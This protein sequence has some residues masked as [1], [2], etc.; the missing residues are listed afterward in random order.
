MTHATI[1]FKLGE[2]N[3]AM[4]RPGLLQRADELV[5]HTVARVLLAMAATVEDHVDGFRSV[6]R[7][8]SRSGW[9]RMGVPAHGTH[10]P[11]RACGQNAGCLAKH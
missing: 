2:V 11:S 6:D 5:P 4:R 3:E 1:Q 9:A 8:P 10:G 7:M